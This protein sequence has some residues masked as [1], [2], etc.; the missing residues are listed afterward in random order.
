MRL[1][2]NVNIHVQGKKNPKDM[3]LDGSAHSNTEANCTSY[4]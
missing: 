1:L 2:L 4:S 3:T